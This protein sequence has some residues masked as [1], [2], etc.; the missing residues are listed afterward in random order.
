MLTMSRA[1]IRLKHGFR[2]ERFSSKSQSF[3]NA[4]TRDAL[5][6]LMSHRGIVIALSSGR[7][8]APNPHPDSSG[9]KESDLLP[10]PQ[11]K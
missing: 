3:P 2:P 8:A 4:N 6:A 7:H 10:E 9:V 1:S 11:I 5:P